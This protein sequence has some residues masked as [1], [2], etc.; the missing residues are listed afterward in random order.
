MRHDL[1]NAY[2]AINCVLLK[3][4]GTPVIDIPVDENEIRDALLKI[5]A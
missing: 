2:E 4:P 3:E 5:D 1:K